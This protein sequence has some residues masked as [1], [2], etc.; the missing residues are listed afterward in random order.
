MDQHRATPVPNGQQKDLAV[1]QI[2][3]ARQ[4]K[5]ER[6]AVAPYVMTRDV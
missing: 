4:V 5:G 6:A 3:A 1:G 2:V